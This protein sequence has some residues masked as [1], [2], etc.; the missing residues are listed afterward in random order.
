MDTGFLKISAVSP[1]VTVADVQ[2]NLEKA[3]EAI[4][5]AK[6]KHI[7][8][9]VFPELFLSGA[10]IGDLVMQSSLLSACKEALQHILKETK[11]FEGIV[12]IGAPLIW[13]G[14]MYDCAVV[15]QNGSILAVVPRSYNDITSSTSSVFAS[16]KD[17]FGQILLCGQQVPF[18][19]TVISI[20]EKAKIGVQI[21]ADFFAQ[22]SPATDLAKNGANIIVSMSA[23]PALVSQ[24]VY[25]KSLLIAESAK[26]NA[27]YVYVS[28]GVGESTTDAVYSGYCAIA[29]NGT[30][31]EESE[32]FAFDGSEVKA[33]ID[34]DRLC[35]DR[36]K[37]A[38]LYVDSSS[39]LPQIHVPT[40]ISTLSPEEVERRFSPLAFIPEN[41]SEGKRRA[42]EILQ[43]QSHALAKRMAHIGCKKLILGLSGGLDSTLAL[44][45]SI[46]TL[47]I[48]HLPTENLHCVTLP[49]FGTTDRTYQNALAL[50]KSFGCELSE[51]SISKAALLHF[52]DIQHN[53]K[54]RDA[55]Y[56]NAQ[57]RERTQILMDLANQT[58]ALLVGTGDLSEL[59]LGWC[60]FNA[61]HMSMYGVNADVPKTLVQHL[62]RYEAEHLDGQVAEILMDVLATPISPELLPPDE[63]GAM[64][65]KTENTLGPYEVHDFYLYYFLRFG[66]A[67]EKLLFM[68]K[69]AFEGVYTN[70]D[71]ETWL[72]LF[73]KRFFTNQF[74]RSCLPDGPK[75]GSVGLS[76]RGDLQMPS[77]ASFASFLD[78]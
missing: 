50:A 59:A 24:D 53:P 23:M 2:T 22:T 9:L 3:I 31:L 62:V 76:P 60:T 77:D 74:K 42:E 61:D 35:A 25:T 54:V 48:L 38:S 56:E 70:E 11:G 41:E 37:H 68:A 45:V 65:Q 26:N 67:P 57:A 7:T 34:V 69:R 13:N 5:D 4:R 27:A 55:T 14:A 6:E 43:I 51:I 29:E 49:G 1:R 75:V 16:G 17:K 72:R 19:Q 73:L 39:A 44:L 63:N 36:M 32:V 46:R 66:F 30:L 8:L 78:F 15:L 18:G 33:D 10:T 28:A 21:G 58:S 52:E 71:L 20:S 64:Q 12:C 47:H 40:A